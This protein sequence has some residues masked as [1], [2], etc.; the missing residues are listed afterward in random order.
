MRQPGVFGSRSRKSAVTTTAG[1]RARQRDRPAATVKIDSK[2]FPVVDMNEA[3]LIVEPYDGDLVVKQRVYFDLIIPLGEKDEMFRAE[4]TVMR[5]DGDRLIGKFNDLRKDAR[6]AIQYI[7]AH[8]NAPLP[9]AT[10]PN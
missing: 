7:A 2:V 4:A 3:G 8:R 10:K 1:S 9:G 6:R 5:R